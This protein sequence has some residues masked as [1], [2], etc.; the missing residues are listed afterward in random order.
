MNVRRLDFNLLVVLEALYLERSVT[1]AGHRLGLTQPA[2]SNGLRRLRLLFDDPLFV[3]TSDGMAPTQRALAV[4]P[5]VQAALDSLRQSIGS[6]GFKPES[7]TDRF[8]LG[9][10]DYI[11]ALH[12]APLV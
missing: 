9:T 5:A 1:R 3:R 6:G 8:V 4:A 11:D 7:S 2:V 10:L 12:I